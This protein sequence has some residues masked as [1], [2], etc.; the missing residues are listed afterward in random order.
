MMRVIWECEYVNYKKYFFTAKSEAGNTEDKTAEDAAELVGG[1]EGLEGGFVVFVDNVFAEE[2]DERDFVA[3]EDPDQ[4]EG[5]DHEEV[6][7]GERQAVEAVQDLFRLG[8][9]LP[10]RRG[11]IIVG[12]MSGHCLKDLG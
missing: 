3:V 9:G 5:E 12:C 6:P 7:A 8:M 11:S 4:S 2:T 10:G 1:G